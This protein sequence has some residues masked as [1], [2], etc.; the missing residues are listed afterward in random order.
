MPRLRL[1]RR[2]KTILT[3][4]RPGELSGMSV[5]STGKI[6]SIALLCLPVLGMAQ[7]TESSGLAS[8]SS[9]QIAIEL[10]NPVTNLR[11]VAFGFE[12][13]T[14]QG[15]LP[16]A[17]DQDTYRITFAPSWPIKLSN[18]KTLT[19]RGRIPIQ[20]DAPNWKPVFYLDWAEFLLRQLPEIDESQ[21]G[22]VNGHDH[23]AD[24]SLDIGYG[25]EGDNGR[26]SMIGVSMVFPTSEDGSAKRGQYLLGPEF[27][28]GR[29][30]DWGI[31]GLRAKHLTNVQGQGSQEVEPYDTNET[32]LNLFFAYSLGNGW[33]IESNPEIL[34]DWEGI[35]DNQWNVPI[36]AGVS[37]TFRMGKVPVK[38]GVELQNFV[39]STDRLA[40]EW[41]LKFHFVPVI[42]GS[43]LD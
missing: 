16:G 23:M 13:Q 15:S 7:T 2:L 25:G 31:Y 11:S 22:F 30:T 34:Y 41:L 5:N 40:P 1:S 17:N 28:L 14:Y 10:L 21:G 19:L 20:G 12:L 27:A 26:F 38:M 36:G 18:G 6:A 33:Q 29:K 42:P 35:D 8:L 43:Y 9:E 39:V 32:T 24:V 37:K 3:S 4:D